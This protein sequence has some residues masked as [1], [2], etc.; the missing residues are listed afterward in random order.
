M[1]KNSL[2]LLTFLTLSF[3]GF[4][5]SVYHNEWIDYSKTYY[6][7]KVMGFGLDTAGAPITT[8]IVR[9]PYTTLTAAGLSLTAAENFQLWRDG[10]EVPVYTS[11]ATGQMGSSDYIEFVGAVNNGK[12]D[13][14]MY[15]NTDFQLSDKWS[16]ET[17]TAAYFLTVNNI[18]SNKRYQP[19]NND[20]LTNTL[21]AT[22]NF[23]YTMGRYFRSLSNGFS[24]SIGENLYSS[25]YDRGE[26]WVSRAVRPVGGGCGAATLPQNFVRLYPDLT[27]PQMTVRINAVGDMQNSRTFKIALNGDSVNTYQMD[28]INYVRTED[29]VDVSKVTGGSASFSIINQSPSLCDEMRVSS[30]ELTYPRLFNLDGKAIFSFT[31][32]SSSTGRFLSISN[33]NHGGIAPVLYDIDNQKRYT[34]DITSP[35]TVKVVLDASYI[36]YNLVL[37]TQN[38]NYFKQINNIETRNFTDFSQSTNQG[39]YLI[40]SNPII[41]GNGS[42]NYVEQYRQYRSSAQGGSFNAR[43]IDI[44]ELADQFAWGV[45]KHPL[46]IKNFLKFAR[47]TFVDSPKYV[48]LIGKGVI[49]NEYRANENNPLA[50]QLNL[51]PTWGNPASDNLLASNGIS[52]TPATPIG[53]LSAINPQEVGDYLLKVKQHDSLQQLPAHTMEAKGWM[54]NVLQITGAND[55]SIG[56][57]IDGYIQNYKNIISDTSFGANVTDFSKTADPASYPDAVNSFKRIYESGAALITYFGHSSNTSLDFNLDDPA[58]YN[59]QYKYPVI[60]ANGC[61]AGNHFLFETNRLNGTT[62]IS[63]KFI[64]SPE[65]GAIE[66]IASTHYGIINYLDLYTKDFYKA[67]GQSRYNQSIGIIVQEA[68]RSSLA[69][70]APNDYFS[71]VHAEQYSLHGD[72]AVVLNYMPEPDYVI[73]KPQI[74]IS[75]S[76]VSVADS[77]FSVKVKVNNIGKATKDSVTL[78]ITREIPDGQI[79]TVLTKTFPVIYLTDSVTV[80]IPIIANR[81][82]GINKITAFAD[83][84][85]QVAEISDS[86]NIAS[87]DVEISDE[88]IRPVYPYNYAII[89]QSDSKLYAS[90]ANPLNASRQYLVELDTTA[91]FNSSS[92]ITKNVT[93]VGG[94]LEFDPATFYQENITYYW[95]VAPSATGSETHWRDFSFVYKNT[96][97][98]GFQQGHIYQHLQSRLERLLLDSSSRQY[99]YTNQLH[100][101]FITNS[102]YPTSGTEDEHFSISVDGSNTIYSA[103]VGASVIFNVFDSLSFK[104]WA[105]TTNPFGAGAVCAAGREYNFEYSYE[106]AASRKNAMDFL[107]AIP[108]GAFVTA[109]LILDQPYGIYAANWAADT[110]LYGPNNSL[111]HRLKDAGFATIDSFH[112]PRTW[113]FAYKKGDTT[114]TPAYNFSEGLYDRITLSVNCHTPNVQG[115]ITSPLFGPAAQ[116]NSIN[117]T[118]FSNEAGNDNPVVNVIGIKKGQPDSILFK[119]D[120]SQHTFN[121]SAVDVNQFPQ[122]RLQMSNTDS[123]TATPYQLSNW[124]ISYTPVPEGA[125]APNLYID[126]PD[127]FNTVTP[128]PGQFPGMMHIGLAFKNVSKADFNALSVK[129]V[130]YDYSGNDITYPL[131]ILRSLPAGDTLHIDQDIDVSS[132]VGLYNVLVYVNPGQ[133]QPEQYSFNNFLYKY[134]FITNSII[135]PVTLLDFN[136]VLEGRKVNT[137]WHVANE[138]STKLY[139][140]EHSANGAA[141][142]KAGV[143]IATQKNSY[144]FIHNDPV[145]GKNYYRL[146]ILDK[147]G[148]FTYSKIREVELSE[149]GFVKIYPNPFRDILYINIKSG[150]GKPSQLKILN[151]YGQQVYLGKMNGM[152]TIKTNTWAAGTYLVQIAEGHA[153]QTFKIQ[154]Q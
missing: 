14:E 40:I 90:T 20:V 93:S 132:L 96:A 94:V 130:L 99:S 120:S 148:K 85:T 11:I 86:N 129:I 116:W 64:L 149:N 6:K 63:E 44:N 81:D 38:G 133:A 62:T 91:L 23:M 39:N 126:I 89:N 21:P 74:V 101:L 2:W 113:A 15:R 45:K 66:Y 151:G 92:K 114:F 16:F 102:I 31:V 87:V 60:I 1:S 50:D 144:S 137:L 136:A 32:D 119:L 141:Y 58:N 84:N 24:A 28:Y 41:Y 13:K 35:D 135:L 98:P 121:I 150:D 78:K 106:T 67:L 122:L 36:P 72:P 69:A 97:T 153:T 146:K 56:N 17:D 139:E 7:M 104:P 76:F 54:K 82:K 27:G 80:N 127:S 105:N 37:T 115:N 47:T 34:T 110:T 128:M 152:A 143:V 9:I 107:D 25:S 95:R 29:Y 33:F 88:E 75:P 111:Y 49:Y 5:Q 109:R 30:V 138:G 8:G 140:V 57:Q 55:L 65:R 145:I 112:F 61:S 124:N 43:I 108:K 134:V 53:R 12:L 154:K 73:E 147:D 4:G 103:C 125:V 19:V 77:S 46:S 131:N 123:A 26:G 59:N 70:T 22:P 52:A 48:F 71:R 117:W 100:N 42:N 18:S 118:G 83:F 68:I 51:V 10:V 3:Y 79:F 142:K